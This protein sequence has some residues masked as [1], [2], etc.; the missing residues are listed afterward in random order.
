MSDHTLHHGTDGHREFLLTCWDDGHCELAIRPDD[1]WAPWSP[2][3]RLDP[4]P[5][6][7]TS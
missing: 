4:V 2:P 6:E 1:P 7:A 5:A 3:V